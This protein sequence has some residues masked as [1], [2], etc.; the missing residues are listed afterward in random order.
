MENK[1]AEYANKLALPFGGKFTIAKISDTSIW[2]DMVETQAQYEFEKK[3]KGEIEVRHHW[4]KDGIAHSLVEPMY[5]S[6]FVQG[7]ATTLDGLLSK[8]DIYNIVSHFNKPIYV[9]L[10][11]NNEFFL[12][13]TFGNAVELSHVINESGAWKKGV[14]E[15]LV[16]AG[17]L[18]EHANYYTDRLIDEAR[19]F[20]SEFVKFHE[21]TF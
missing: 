1:Y 7:Y 9:S 3:E 20:H 12:M 21:T 16:G 4:V 10:S 11:T 6:E 13:D 14:V 18:E 15:Y 17:W 2:V 5:L 19:R 8:D